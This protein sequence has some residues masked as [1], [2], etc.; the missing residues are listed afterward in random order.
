VHV[1]RW[2][3]H[4]AVAWAQSAANAVGVRIPSAECGRRVFYADVRVMPTWDRIV[5]LAC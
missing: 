5:V 1:A 3:G 2:G 4:G